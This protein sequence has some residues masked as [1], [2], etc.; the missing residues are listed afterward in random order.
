MKNKILS[1]V[2][3]IALMAL[4]SCSYI[5]GDVAEQ[6][7]ATVVVENTDGSYESFKVY[8]DKLENKS[9]GAK[10][11]LE[12]LNKNDDLYLEMVDSTYGAYVSA[13][14]SIKESA[15]DKMYVIVYTSLASDSYDGAP[16]L[17][18]KGATL[19]Q[20]GL[21]LSGMTVDEGV[22]ILLRLE[23]SPY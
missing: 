6:G 1:L 12:H 8:L 23:E 21:G 15:T 17:D 7:V 5:F 11:V 3:V 9:E 22:I 14:G 10:G 19:Y 13:V 18:Y 2:L 16:T 20:A 4:T